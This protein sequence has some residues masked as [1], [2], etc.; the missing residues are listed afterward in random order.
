MA[1]STTPRVSAG[2][3]AERQRRYGYQW[4]LLPHGGAD[5]PTYAWAAIGYGGQ[6]LVIV[7]EHR[8]IGVFMGWNIYDKPSLGSFFA[9][10]RLLAAVKAD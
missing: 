8:L 9:L 7:P 2:G 3:S 1:A 4:W 6:L 10:D 5:E